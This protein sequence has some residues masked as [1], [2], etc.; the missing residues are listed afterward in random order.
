[1][2]NEEIH[3][4]LITKLQ[5]LGFWIINHDKSSIE[6][7]SW[8]RSF[9]GTWTLL[10]ICFFNRLSTLYPGTWRDKYIR[11]KWKGKIFLC[12]GKMTKLWNILFSQK[13]ICELKIDDGEGTT[14][15]NPSGLDSRWY[16]YAVQFCSWICCH[17]FVHERDHPCM[18][19][20]IY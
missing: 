18:P 6:Q 17:K 10:G 1:M 2:I 19:T 5:W 3:L 15:S 16:V 20:R 11:R 8:C 4:C 7:V 13:E 14:V 9:L 12:H